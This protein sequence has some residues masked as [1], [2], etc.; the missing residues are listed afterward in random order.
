[1][2]FIGTPQHNTL[3]FERC[4]RFPLRNRNG[5]KFYLSRMM[6]GIDGKTTANDDDD[7]V[8]VVVYHFMRMVDDDDERI[9]W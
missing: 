1:L 9:E 7:D 2:V 6:D 3:A 4:E 8:F 5:L